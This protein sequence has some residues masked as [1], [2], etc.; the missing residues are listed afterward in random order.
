MK[1][2]A[3][4]LF[5]AAPFGLRAEDKPVMRIFELKYVDPKQL[6]NLLNNFGAIQYSPQLHTIT[7]NTHNNAEMSEAERLIQRYDVPPP[8]VPNVEVTIYMMSA[9]PTPS[10]TAIPQEL[11]PVVKQLKGMFSYKGY[12]LIDTE[13][14]RVR[15]GQGGDASA[16]VDNKGPT[17]SKTISQM[18]FRSATP[19]TDE[20]GRAMRIDGLKVGL[21]IP[22]PTNAKGEF[23]YID[24]GIST[25]VDIREGQ[26]VVVGKVNMDGADR[27]SIVVLAAKIVE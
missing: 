21:K 10:A 3:V 4:L 27:A 9:L 12:Q 8:P 14:I 18:K 15:A 7:F 24:T 17:G 11:E 20:K 2:L 5:I 19:S 22:L 25:D 1:K 23:T 13:V 16:V 6:F 26:K